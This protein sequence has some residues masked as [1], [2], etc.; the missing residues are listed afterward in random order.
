MKSAL[1]TGILR[2]GAPFRVAIVPAGAFAE[3]ASTKEAPRRRSERFP[4]P[5]P[6]PG[7]RPLP[8]PTSPRRLGRPRPRSVPFLLNSWSG[9]VGDRT[10]LYG[11]PPCVFL[12]AAPLA[13]R[14][15]AQE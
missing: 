8:R 3:R 7:G 13:E 15:N 12:P 2:R 1:S 4:R 6:E 5:A 11:S 9:R 14:N 10:A